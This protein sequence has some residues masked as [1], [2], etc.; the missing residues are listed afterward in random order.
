MLTEDQII[1]TLGRYEPRCYTDSMLD[2]FCS[3]VERAVTDAERT[4]GEADEVREEKR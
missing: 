2:R 1:S 3:D 4:I